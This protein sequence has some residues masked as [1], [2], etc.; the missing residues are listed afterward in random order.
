MHQTNS[1]HVGSHLVEGFEECFMYKEDR[2]AKTIDTQDESPCMTTHDCNK[3][4]LS[5][6][7]F[8]SD[9]V[10][11][12]SLILESLISMHDKWLGRLIMID[13]LVRGIHIETGDEKYIFLYM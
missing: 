6:S 4:D 12:I 5:Y 3:I 8:Y 1:T 11:K 13:Y 10:F 2:Y 9:L 7:G